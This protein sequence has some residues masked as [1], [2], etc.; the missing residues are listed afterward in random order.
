MPQAQSQEYHKNSM[1]N[2]RAAINPHIQY[3]DRDFDI[4]SDKGF[5]QANDIL[6]G[7]LKSSLKKR[8]SRPTKQRNNYFR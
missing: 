7:K 6:D 2:I 1:N 5:R 3:L 4:V 8:L